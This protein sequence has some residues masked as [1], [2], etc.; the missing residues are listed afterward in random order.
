MNSS[1]VPMI[2][3]FVCA[4][5][6]NT[7]FTTSVVNDIKRDVK[8]ILNNQTVVNND[9]K[10]VSLNIKTEDKLTNNSLKAIDSFLKDLKLNGIER[11]SFV[12]TKVNFSD[13]K[14]LIIENN[15]VIESINL[16]DRDVLSEKY[17]VYIVRNPIQ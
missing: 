15:F 12:C 10:E 6:L 11:S 1:L 14:K 8:T 3:G 2:F 5:L 13:V 7:C 9:T 4:I 16:F 17:S